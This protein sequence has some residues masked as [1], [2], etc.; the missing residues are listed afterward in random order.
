VIRLTRPF[1]ILAHRGASGYAPENTFAS[2]DLA[3]TMCPD[4]LETDLRLT[5]DGVI[6]VFHDETVDRMTAGSGPV[7][8]FGYADLRHLVIDGEHSGKYPPQH[9]PR[10]EELLQ[11]YLGRVPLCLEIKEHGVIDPLVQILQ[12][13]GDL[14]GKIEFTSFE[15]DAAVAIRAALPGA[16]VGMLVRDFDPATIDRVADAGFAEICPWVRATTP[17][18]VRQAHDLGLSVRTYGIKSIDDLRL[19]VANHADGTT[20]NWPDWVDRSA[21]SAAGCAAS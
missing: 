7:A 12:P 20:L 13:L 2:F 11:H 6:A 9:V 5:C 21:G 14:T 8:G 1:R 4:A 18:T 16:K 3:L 19:A 17:A 10:V 15:P